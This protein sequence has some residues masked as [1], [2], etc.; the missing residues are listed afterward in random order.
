MEKNKICKK[1][2]TGVIVENMSKKIKDRWLKILYNSNNNEILNLI[3]DSIEENNNFCNIFLENI[4]EEKKMEVKEF[5]FNFI[6][7]LW[8]EIKLNK[9]LEEALNE[10]SSPEPNDLPIPKFCL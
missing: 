3:F 4:G 1:K 8:N 5:K 9:M 2:N 7:Y 6:K 10:I